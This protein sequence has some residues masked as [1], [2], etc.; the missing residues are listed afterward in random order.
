MRDG[1]FV[2]REFKVCFKGSLYRSFARFDLSQSAR[3]IADGEYEFLKLFS[4]CICAMCIV[5]LSRRP[6]E[7]N[8][9]KYYQA[10][11]LEM[12]RL[13]ERNERN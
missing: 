5:V 10:I 4:R 13:G 11:V 2:L 8:G 7:T 1:S 3:C 12:L 9:G 6:I